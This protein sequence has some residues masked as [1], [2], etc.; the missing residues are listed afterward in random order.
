MNFSLCVHVYNFQVQKILKV[1]RQTSVSHGKFANFI[2][3]SQIKKN[4]SLV[5][6]HRIENQINTVKSVWV[7]LS[8]DTKHSQWQYEKIIVQP[9]VS[10]IWTMKYFYFNLNIIFL[11]LFWEFYALMQFFLYSHRYSPGLLQVIC[12]PQSSCLFFFFNNLLSPICA[13]HSWMLSHSMG[14]D[15]PTRVH[16]LQR[17]SSL[18]Q[19]HYLSVAIQQG[20]GACELLPLPRWNVGQTDLLRVF[21]HVACL[22]I[23]SVGSMLECLPTMHK[24]LGSFPKA[25]K[26]KKYYYGS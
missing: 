8:L 21:L 24:A 12:I 9:K 23:I 7:I 11:S 3:H 19:K 14:C 5:Q 13:A 18:S 15:G 1:R 2:K 17:D 22:K 4:S 25:S 26:I 16:T 10:V 6:S 20:V